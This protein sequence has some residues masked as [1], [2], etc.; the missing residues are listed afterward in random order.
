[1]DCIVRMWLWIARTQ[2]WQGYWPSLDTM[3]VIWQNTVM[4][5]E[6]T[7]MFSLDELSLEVERL[8]QELGLARIQQDN[9]VS[10]IPDART[11]RYYTSLGL[12]DR[13]VIEG[14]QGKYAKRHLLQLVAVKALQSISLPLAEIQARLYGLTD[15]ELEG[16]IN[17][18]A[19]HVS[20]SRS[21]D[22]SS[23]QTQTDALVWRELTIEP[24]LKISVEEKWSPTSDPEILAKR[25]CAAINA[26]Q[27]KPRKTNGG[28]TDEH[29]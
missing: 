1:M 15:D 25:I 22:E 16:V 10:A 11:I 23:S 26:L 5:V 6:H 14:R 21:K 28:S 12:L 24:G 19:S 20:E 7:R 4:V 9:R 27:N 17:A 13:P 2:S 8:L 3:T 18:V 29:S